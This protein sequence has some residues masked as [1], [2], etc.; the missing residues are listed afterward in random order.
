MSDKTKAFWNDKKHEIETLLQQ[1][2]ASSGEHAKYFT[3]AE[4]TWGHA[5]PDALAKVNQEIIGPYIL[6]EIP[7]YLLL[8]VH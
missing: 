1:L 3:T 8:S 6:G 5:I 4:Q 2:A 7:R